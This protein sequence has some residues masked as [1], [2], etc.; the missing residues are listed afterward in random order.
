MSKSNYP[1]VVVLPDNV[2]PYPTITEFLIARFPKISRDVWINRISEKKIHD[3][4]GQPVNDKTPYVPGLK[5]YYYREVDT[6]PLVPFKESIIYSDERILVACK[7]HFL[8][9]TPSG[10]YVNECL[11]NRLKNNTGNSDLTPLNRI[12]LDTAGLV[13]FSTDRDTRGLYHNLFTTGAIEKTYEAVT[14]CPVKPGQTELMIRNRLVKGDPW[15]RME[16]ADGP[17]NAV[18]HI[19][20]LKFRNTRALCR[21]TPVTGKKHQLRVHLSSIGYGI[22]NDRFYPD[23]SPEK[24]PVFDTPLQLLAKKIRF[25]DPVSGIKLEFQS[26][27]TLSE[28]W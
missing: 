5:I 13:L 11:I 19:E 16:I 4:D 26:D 9:V 14:R 27:R 23:L 22:L 25:T 20:F 28:S 12:D 3:A 10:R 1:S 6:E 18:T 2:K 7:P 21:L 15:F 24:A 8:P 17:P